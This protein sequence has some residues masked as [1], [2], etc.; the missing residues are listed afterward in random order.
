MA[1]LSP[2][3]TA[4]LQLL[5]TSGEFIHTA[6]IRPDGI[7]DKVAAEPVA[8]EL[9]DLL[10]E[11]MSSADSIFEARWIPAGTNIYQTVTLTPVDGI[12]TPGTV[13]DRGD[14]A[15]CDF[16][17]RTDDGRETRLT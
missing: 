16:T 1:P 6:Q 8:A 2:D 7:A 11:L 4:R 9:A 14:T 10:A 13:N 12:L 5:Y 3:T 15:Y 17:G